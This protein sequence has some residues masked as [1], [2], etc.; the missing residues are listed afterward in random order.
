MLEGDSLKKM[1]FEAYWKNP[2]M[3]WKYIK[4]LEVMGLFRYDRSSTLPEEY[5]RLNAL[6]MNEHRVWV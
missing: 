3:A 2:K 1:M 4:L 6:P 5:A